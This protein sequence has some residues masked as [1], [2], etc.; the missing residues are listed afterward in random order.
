MYKIIAE[1]I[2]VL[3]KIY[4]IIN[5]LSDTCAVYHRIFLD[6]EVDFIFKSWIFLENSRLN[7]QEQWHMIMHKQCYSKFKKYQC[8]DFLKFSYSHIIFKSLISRIE[9]VSEQQFFKFNVFFSKL[10]TS[11]VTH[12]KVLNVYIQDNCNFAVN[13]RTSIYWYQNTTNNSS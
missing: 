11:I 8:Y 7:F 2:P 9:K 1:K 10:V 4:E 3:P 6:E 13:L 5:S 12:G